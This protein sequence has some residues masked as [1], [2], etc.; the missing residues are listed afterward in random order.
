[1]KKI[2]IYIIL[3][4]FFQTLSASISNKIIVKIENEII[5]DYEFQNKLLTSLVLSNQNI[6]QENINLNKKKTL[7]FLIDLKLK[8]LE[9]SKYK[10]QV[11]NTKVDNYI[12]A[13]SS[14]QNIEEAKIKFNNN[15]L[16]F[17]LFYEEIKTQFEWQQ[18]IY[19]IYSRKIEIDENSIN[20][21]LNKLKK[22]ESDIINVNISEI[23]IFL[24]NDSSDEEKIKKIKN[25]IATD[26]FKKTAITYSDSDTSVNGGVLGWVNTKSLSSNVYN[27]INKL[28]IGEISDP[29][30]K[31]NSFLILKLNDKKISKAKNIDTI[32]LKDLLIKK[33]KNELF[34][35]YSRS[36]LSKLKNTSLI[37]YK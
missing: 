6:T 11:N 15:N 7:N 31:Q 2:L 8:R 10:L 17:E 24:K 33:R 4:F 19:K 28:Q 18:L 5:T 22:K 21:E 29:I 13:V 35:L 27:I 37:E 16:N 30:I 36:H 9:L 14:Y 20:Q 3:V 32:K 34:E 1:M 26:G 25:L 23:E 12:K